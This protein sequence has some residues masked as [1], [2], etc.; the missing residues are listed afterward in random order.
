MVI[1]SVVVTYGRNDAGRAGRASPF[2][3][4]AWGYGGQARL[5]AFALPPSL[6]YGAASRRG[7]PGLGGQIRPIQS[8]S[9]QLKPIQTKKVWGDGGLGLERQG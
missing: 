7:E 6:R 2:H 4:R 9:N 5:Q 8:N 1:H 3:L